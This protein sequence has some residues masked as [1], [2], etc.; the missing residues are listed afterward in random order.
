M[1]SPNPKY[2]MEVVTPDVPA[3]ASPAPDLT[4]GQSMDNALQ[5][6]LEETMKEEN[7]ELSAAAAEQMPNENVDK[8][9]K[10]VDKETDVTKDV[11]EMNAGDFSPIKPEL[12]KGV[13]TFWQAQELNHEI[14]KL[15]KHIAELE[16]KVA[17]EK[18]GSSIW[19]EAANRLKKEKEDGEQKFIVPE[20][21]FDQAVM[22]KA[23]GKNVRDW[24][25]VLLIDLR[26]CN[27]LEKNLTREMYRLN[28]RKQKCVQCL[29]SLQ[30]YTVSD[31]A[32]HAE[33]EDFII[34]LKKDDKV[35]LVSRADYEKYMASLRADPASAKGIPPTASTT[36]DVSPMG[37]KKDGSPRGSPGGGSASASATG[38]EK[39]SKL[40]SPIYETSKRSR[41]ER[42]LLSDEITPS[43]E[44]SKMAKVFAMNS[45]SLYTSVSTSAYG[46]RLI[47]H[48]EDK[49]GF[50]YT[51]RS[52]SA[53]SRS[54]SAS[55]KV[56]KK[57]VKVNAANKTA[58]DGDSKKD[59]D[60]D[61]D[62]KGTW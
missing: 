21:L 17:L 10:L 39:P 43:P 55:C 23:A 29:L 53:R 12:G 19:E 45:D 5:V 11:E 48:P 44:T 13:C 6:A 31:I 37:K 46:L 1:V 54:R 58:A 7:M 9:A 24:H 38:T 30:S 20:E 41:F 56:T 22:K 42:R 34:S 3:S 28:K 62:A 33:L 36:P 57:S 14:A 18:L 32:G 26:N 4:V 47:S 16:Q 59:N 27:Q 25:K 52:R 51:Q 49:V 50:T 40:L 15:K 60:K 2:K 8:D 61:V 35:M